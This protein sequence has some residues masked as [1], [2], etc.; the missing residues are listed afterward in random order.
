MRRRTLLAAALAAAPALALAAVSPRPGPEDPRIQVV[1][2]DP[3]QVVT[4]KVAFGYAL[5]LEFAPDERIE[6]VAVGA[7]SVWQITPNKSADH[8]FIKALQGAAVTNMT[9]IT[10]ER[11]YNFELMPLVNVDPSAP[12]VV[13]F[14]YPAGPGTPEHLPPAPP[15]TY[16][17]SGAKA[18]R[19]TDIS[20][21]GR[22]T[23]L[24]WAPGAPIPAV[25]ARGP[26]GQ[27]VLV[28]GAFRDGRY[29]ISQVADTLIFRLG[30]QE[31]RA[32]RRLVKPKK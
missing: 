23:T 11:S 19:P 20:D 3:Q 6:N 12:F 16:R 5:T 2:Y 8:L 30:N 29:V 24:A 21:D 7:S 25:Y 1:E 13:R 27:E 10:G 17:L 26:G 31:A 4:L 15:A 32:S 22:F 18:L 14:I 9:V 28:N